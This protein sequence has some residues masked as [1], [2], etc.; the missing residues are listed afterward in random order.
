MGVADGM[1]VSVGVL[2]DVGVGVGVGVRLG[3]IGVLLGVS[4]GRSGELSP[5]FSR[6]SIVAFGGG[7]VKVGGTANAIASSFWGSNI[8]G[9]RVG[10]GGCSR[11]PACVSSKIRL[12]KS[13][14][15]LVLVAGMA[16]MIPFV[17]D[18]CQH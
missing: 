13:R 1:G 4:V 18:L 2:V 9:T 3:K 11:Q 6:G 5:K 8:W 14:H 10:K 16:G 7:G 12:I 17:L 15:L